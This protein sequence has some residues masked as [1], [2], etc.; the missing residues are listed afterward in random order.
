MEFE[1]LTVSQLLLCLRE[2]NQKVE[3]LEIALREAK[4]R[5]ELLTCKTKGTVQGRAHDCAC[6][7][8]IQSWDMSPTQESVPLSIHYQAL[9]TSS[10]ISASQTSVYGLKQC[11]LL[12]LTVFTLLST[13][14][15]LPALCP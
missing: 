10:E 4:E 12:G 2:G 11:G 14:S 6:T 8:T 9:P 3:R 7:A 1:E 15:C 13:V 5:Y